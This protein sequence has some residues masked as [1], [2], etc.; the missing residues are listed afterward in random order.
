MEASYQRFQNEYKL[1]SEGIFYA[2][3]RDYQLKF[4]A[5]FMKRM[6]KKNVP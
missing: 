6:G 3:I 2:Y 5:K 4:V 1:K